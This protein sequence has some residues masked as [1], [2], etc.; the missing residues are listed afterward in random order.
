MNNFLE[1]FFKFFKIKKKKKKFKVKI[2]LKFLSLECF[3][4]EIFFILLNLYKIFL[5]M[6]KIFLK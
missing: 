3:N 6:E 1:I 2:S 4:S 5:L